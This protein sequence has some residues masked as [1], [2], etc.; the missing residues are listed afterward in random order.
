M[1]ILFYTGYPG[2][3]NVLPEMTGKTESTP[4]RTLAKT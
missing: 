2:I 4:Y 1:D 3:L